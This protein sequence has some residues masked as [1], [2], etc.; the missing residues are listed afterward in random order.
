MNDPPGSDGV[1]TP[2]AVGQLD[3]LL[4]PL[5]V[6]TPRALGHLDRLLH[7]LHPVYVLIV[8]ARDWDVHPD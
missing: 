1:K 4:H 5:G 3:R 8:D 6:E 7:L 2:T